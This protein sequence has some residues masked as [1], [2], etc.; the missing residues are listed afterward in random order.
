MRKRRRIEK[1][2]SKAHSLYKNCIL[3]LLDLSLFSHYVYN[4]VS[5]RTGGKIRPKAQRKNIHLMLE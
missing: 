3:L 1:I 2:G 5:F 4:S